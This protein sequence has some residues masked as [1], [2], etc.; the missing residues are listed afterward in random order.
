MKPPYSIPLFGME[1]SHWLMNKKQNA[2]A[3]SNDLVSIAWTKLPF[4]VQ[5]FTKK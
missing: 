2:L 4:F 1:L 5:G 3:P